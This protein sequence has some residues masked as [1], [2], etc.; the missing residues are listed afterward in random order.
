MKKLARL[1]LVLF[2]TQLLAAGIASAV[3]TPTTGDQ[4]SHVNAMPEDDPP[5]EGF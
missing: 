2:A 1:I 3:I 5:S 4:K